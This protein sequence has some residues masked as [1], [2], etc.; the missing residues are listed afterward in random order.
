MNNIARKGINVMIV[1]IIVTVINLSIYVKMSENNFQHHRKYLK[2]KKISNLDR[3]CQ[4]ESQQFVKHEKI[5]NRSYF[6][7]TIKELRYLLDEAYQQMQQGQFRYAI[8]DADSVLKETIKMI[9]QHKNGYVSDDL[10]MNMKICERRMLFG[11]NKESMDKLYEVYHIC[12]S[13]DWKLNKEKYANHRKVYF[14]IMQ[15]KD[16][17]NF[18]EKEVVY[19]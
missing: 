2:L 4:E 7:E 16:L 9:L 19:S 10:L 5:T 18:A 13:N 1:N 11:D 3:N 12:N 15:L 8:Y 6:A 17:L 14:V